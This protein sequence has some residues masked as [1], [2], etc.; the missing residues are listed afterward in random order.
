MRPN[1]GFL[2]S[3]FY[4]DY[5]LQTSVPN[6]FLEL[7]NYY[8]LF[9]TPFYLIYIN[10]VITYRLLYTI[11][12]RLTIWKNRRPLLYSNFLLP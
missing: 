8:V 3:S 2:V 9:N 6:H 10:D 11:F 7:G 5:R 12:I 4:I 1:F